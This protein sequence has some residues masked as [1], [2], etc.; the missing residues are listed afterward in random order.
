MNLTGIR[1][2]GWIYLSHNRDQSRVLVNAVVKHRIL[3]NSGNF[4]S[5]RANVSLKDRSQGAITEF[6][7]IH[8]SPSSFNFTSHSNIQ[9]FPNVQ[10]S[11]NAILRFP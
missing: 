5:C 2:A 4:L 6:V 1:W 7:F 8:L 9:V 3:Q 10:L 11:G